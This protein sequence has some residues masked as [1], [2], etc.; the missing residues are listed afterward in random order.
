MEYEYSKKFIRDVKLFEHDA[1]FA[2][3]LAGKIKEI[4]RANSIEEVTGLEDIRGRKVFYRFKITSGKI[5]Y[6]IGLKV[7]HQVVWLTLLDNHKK[8]FYER[9]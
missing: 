2:R 1:A 3:Q 8:R 9:I 7:L 5:V 4:E 6:R